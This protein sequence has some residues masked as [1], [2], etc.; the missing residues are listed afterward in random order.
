LDPLARR[1]RVTSDPRQAAF[2]FIADPVQAPAFDDF[3]LG[4]PQY[5]DRSATL[6]LQVEGFGTGQRLLLS[7]PGIA[8]VQSF[9]A[10]PLP[11]DFQ[12]RIAAN[13][14][15]FPRGVDVILVSPN[16]VAALPRS[17]ASARG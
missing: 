16:A 15:L 4:T 6:V 10:Q 3:S 7:G 8:D 9:S 12:T 14:A 2:A 1:R 5:P 11:P 17:V 13:R